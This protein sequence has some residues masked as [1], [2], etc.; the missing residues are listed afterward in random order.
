MTSRRRKLIDIYWNRRQ[1]VAVYDARF[2]CCDGNIVEGFV[3][4]EYY[5]VVP[6]LF[7]ILLRHGG[8]I[9]EQCVW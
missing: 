1:T 9:G 4:H 7:A 5:P 3:Q 8:P 2:K 6:I